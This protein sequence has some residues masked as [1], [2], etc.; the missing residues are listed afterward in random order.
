MAP[1]ASPALKKKSYHILAH[2]ALKKTGDH[3]EII[4]LAL[5]ITVT[6]KQRCGVSNSLQPLHHQN[7]QNIFI[8]VYLSH[9]AHAS[10]RLQHSIYCST[11]EKKFCHYSMSEFSQQDAVKQL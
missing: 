1:V 9:C 7:Y 4:Q 10:W 11:R 8:L 5:N 2:S 3:Q 6:L